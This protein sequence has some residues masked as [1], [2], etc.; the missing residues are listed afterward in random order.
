[1]DTQD[2]RKDDN[3]LTLQNDTRKLSLSLS[4]SST[5]TV[6]TAIACIPSRAFLLGAESIL[7]QMLLCHAQGNCIASPVAATL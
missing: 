3:I 6:I 5:Q 1:M 4:Q 7:A 2:L